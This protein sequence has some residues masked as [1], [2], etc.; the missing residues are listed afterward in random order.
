MSKAT[1]AGWHKEIEYKYKLPSK[2]TAY[3]VNRLAI[4]NGFQLKSYTLQRD[5]IPD[6]TDWRLKN[7]NLLLRF[8]E[9]FDLDTDAIS[10]L[11]TLKIK[12]MVGNESQNLELEA[13]IEQNSNIQ[14]IEEYIYKSIGRSIDLLRIVKRQGEYLDEIK[15]NT[16]RMLL[17][18]KRRELIA[19]DRKTLLAID[20]LP[21]PLGFFAELEAL[22]I[23]N[24]IQD[25]AKILELRQSWLVAEDYGE[26][27]KNLDKK[28]RN[29]RT[30]I[31]NPRA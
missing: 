28:N 10:T 15:L 9:S 5:W 19:P 31:F 4:K 27:V 29:Q 14:A 23:I 8:R 17:E 7:S 24:T 3:S 21:H 6:F 25:Y 18:K 20:E 26:L 22:S 11:I 2:N 13:T 30:L 16:H 12:R 1:A